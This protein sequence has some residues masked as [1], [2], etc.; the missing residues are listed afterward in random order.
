M[1]RQPVVTVATPSSRVKRRV[2]RQLAR[3][4][5]GEAHADIRVAQHLGQALRRAVALGDQ[6]DPPAAGQPAA[7]VVDRRGRV[8]AVG[9][10][11][12]GGGEQAVVLEGEVGQIGQVGRS[13]RLGRGR[14]RGERGDDHQGTPMADA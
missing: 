4:Q 7:D 6:A 8:A 13:G 5:S 12:L 14:I 10:G 3:L 2:G 1:V 9:R 11:G